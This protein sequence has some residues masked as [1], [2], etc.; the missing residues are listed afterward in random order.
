M[1]CDIIFTKDG[2]YCSYLEWICSSKEKYY[3]SPDEYLWINK[4]K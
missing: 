2:I 3:K 4:V 1:I